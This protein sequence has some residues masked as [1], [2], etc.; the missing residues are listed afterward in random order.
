MANAFEGFRSVVAWYGSKPAPLAELISECQRRVALRLG[1]AFHPYAIEQIH[2]TL[3]SLDPRGV[4][5][6][7]AIDLTRLLCFVETSPRLP[8]QIQVGGFPNRPYAF[9][10]RDQTPYARSFALHEGKAVVI[11]WPMNPAT[12]AYPPG[13]DTLR[14]E[15]ES[16]GVRHH[17][18]RTPTDIDNDAYF[19]IG[20][21][22]AAA[23]EPSVLEDAQAELRRYLSERAPT[24][25]EIAVDDLSVAIS[26]DETLAPHSTR[27]FSLQKAAQLNPSDRG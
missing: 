5:R 14:R 3:I 8:M 24:I 10:S 6:P 23:I 26:S 25:V 21:Y 13:L 17:Y 12:G 20:L 7:A 22:D 4:P 27:I 15:L 11:G 2:S 19:R 9:T 16:F 18:H 1:T